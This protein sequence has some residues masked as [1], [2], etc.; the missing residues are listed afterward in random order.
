MGEAPQAKYAYCRPCMRLMEN[1]VTAVELMKGVVQVH[2]RALGA[3][4]ADELAE[5]FK[6]RL[7]AKSK[8]KPPS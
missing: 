2:A 8:I 5:R 7:L 6:N 4:N 1:P 3:V